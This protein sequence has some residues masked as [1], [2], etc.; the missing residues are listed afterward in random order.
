LRSGKPRELPVAD[1]AVDLA[2]LLEPFANL[3]LGVVLAG[4]L[5]EERLQ[6]VGLDDGVARNVEVTDLVPLSFVDRNP[7]LDPPGLLVVGVVQHLELGH[8]DVGANVAPIAVERLN[9]LRVVVELGFLIGAVVADDGEKPGRKVDEVLKR[10]ALRFSFSWRLSVPSLI[11]LLPTKSILRILTLGPSSI[12]K[13]MCTSFGPPWTS[14]ISWVTLANWNPFSRSMSR[15]MPSTFANQR[16]IDERVEADLR[17]RLFQLLVDLRD[18][19]LLRSGVVDDLDALP[20]LHVVGHHLADGSVGELVVG[21]LD[22]QVVEEV[23]V[24]QPV[25]I[26]L[27]DFLGGVGVRDPLPLRR[28][29]GFQLDVIEVGL[30][31]D[32][33][34]AALRLE[35]RRDVEDDRTRARRRL[36]SG[37]ACCPH[38]VTA[39][40]SARA[41]GPPGAGPTR[42]WRPTEHAAAIDSRT[43]RYTFT[44]LD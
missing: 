40:S 37:R 28:R 24:P 34:R 31:F 23:G 12:W 41:P 32:D 1:A 6:V 30:R 35:A 7:E 14:L 17:V 11:A 15:T 43:S 42:S 4:G 27:D 22:E 25:E 29:A 5:L 8:A 2:R 39:G 3:L 38:T 16:R 21:D 44:I 13:V 26:V 33:R 20:L 18:L 9:L 19:D 10:S 36:A